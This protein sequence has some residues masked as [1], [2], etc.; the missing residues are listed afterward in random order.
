MSKPLTEEELYKIINHLQFTDDDK[1]AA[2][3]QNQEFI[4]FSGWAKVENNSIIIN[5]LKQGE[6]PPL[7]QAAESVKLKKNGEYMEGEFHI[8]AEDSLE[9]EIQYPPLFEITVAADRMTVYFQLFSMEQH[10]RRLRDKEPSNKLLI[11]CEEDPNT[12]IQTLEFSNI[13]IALQ[14]MSI[15][16]VQYDRIQKELMAPTYE[17][18]IVAEG[19]RP[20]PSV[21]ANLEIFFKETVES[22]YEE[23]NGNIDY[24]NHLRIPSAKQGEILARKTPM[25]PG[26]KGWDVYG[27]VAEP[28]RPKDVILIGKDH[29][30]ITPE[31]EVVALREG[32]PRITGERIKVV[33]ITPAYIVPSDV[34]L[35]TGNIVFSGDVLVYGNVS[36]GM[37]VEALGNVYISGSVYNATITATGSI[38]I[39]G[40]VIGSGLYS[41][42][43]GVLYN[44]LF[45]H[46]V[47]LNELLQNLK[48]AGKHLNKVLESQ[49]KTA[50]VGQTLQLLVETKFREI[51]SVAKEIL[52]CITNIQSIQRNHL[53]ELR[54]KLHALLQKSTFLQ[55]DPYEFLLDLQN[56]LV[57]VS[58]S[59]KRCEETSVQS[60]LPQCHLST[61]MSNGNI[62]IRREGVLQSN[63]FSKNNIV[64]YDQKSVCRGSNLE[65]GNTI[66]AM[67]VGSELGGSSKLQAGNKIYVRKMFN[68]R[69]I[70]NRHS[71]EIL[72]PIEYAEIVVKDNRLAVVQHDGAGWDDEEI[73]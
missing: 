33:E 17:P 21:D 63:L 55:T 43:Y 32:R 64:F 25:K 11:E 38:H 19:V 49:G 50:H 51:P 46:S 4:P 7:L 10:L 54:L 35:E 18:V 37:I 20:V 70:V 44:R 66:S 60:D 71:T 22:L 73:D 41:G 62:L 36:D 14:D 16:N 58:G 3:D 72:E 9:W 53:E 30:Q 8:K 31:G 68:G 5:P 26:K 45:S 12:V 67:Y 52:S 23:V 39:R 28:T 42:Y 61:I 59:I 13:V 69:V 2:E 40:N 1:E 47:K 6:V 15:L 34:N 48:S 65:A 56:M 24:R 27:E 29:I 57:S